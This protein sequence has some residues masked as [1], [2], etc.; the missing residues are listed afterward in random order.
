MRL[1]KIARKTLLTAL[2]LNANYL[3]GKANGAAISAGD[4]SGWY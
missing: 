1:L 4:I 3:E 2:D